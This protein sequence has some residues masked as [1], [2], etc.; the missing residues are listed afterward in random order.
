LVGRRSRKI[1]LAWID[2]I[3]KNNLCGI[4]F[5]NEKVYKNVDLGGWRSFFFFFF[6]Y[7]L[8]RAGVLAKKKKKKKK[9]KE[10]WFLGCFADR[11]AATEVSVLLS[12][13]AVE[14]CIPGS[15]QLLQLGRDRV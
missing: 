4:P 13:N 10:G 6:W 8:F 12:S 5:W 1:K 11:P 9:K 2:R 7:V 15:L 3:K 14:Q